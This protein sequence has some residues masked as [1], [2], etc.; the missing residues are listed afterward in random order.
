MTQRTQNI[1]LAPVGWVLKFYALLPWW[2][3]YAHATGM[4][5]LAYYVLRY[6]RKVVRQNLTECFPD[7]TEAERK[8]IEKEYYKHFADY[9]FETIKIPRISDDEIKRRVKFSNVHL[10]DDALDRGQSVMLYASHYGNWEWITS[11]MLWLRPKTR[12]R[13]GVLGQTYHPLE[14][15]WFDRY[16]LKLR[17]HWG[18]ICIPGKQVFRVMLRSQQ[19]GKPIALGFIS[20]QHPLK[21]DEGHVIKFLNHPTAMITGTELIACKLDMRAL[22]FDMR[23]VSRGHY[24]VDLVLLSDHAAQEKKG[25][26]TNRYAR[27]LEQ[28]INAEPA[29]WLWTHKR[30]KRK[31]EYPEG[32]TTDN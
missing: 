18:T 8:K 17:Q 16:F 6:R 12:E 3:L 29:Y 24:E 1:L 31:V 32:Y 2:L 21:G 20:D 11:V 15:P 13:G 10:I 7:K 26:I 23:K 30:W 22:C 28:R 27:L 9:F 25:D 4:Y 19:Q 14:N 5:F